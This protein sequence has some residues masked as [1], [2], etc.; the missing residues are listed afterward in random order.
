V[1]LRSSRN[2]NQPSK[3]SPRNSDGLHKPDSSCGTSRFDDTDDLVF[4]V[5]PSPRPKDL[6]SFETL[7][8]LESNLPCYGRECVLSTLRVIEVV[9][10]KSA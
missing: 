4:D 1:V 10:G 9:Q 3:S 6:C 2:P 8:K 5:L 7:V